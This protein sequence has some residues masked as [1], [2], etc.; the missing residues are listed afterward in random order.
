M[1]IFTL[2]IFDR[3]GNCLFHKDWCRQKVNTLTK[4]EERKL[5]FGMIH[6]IKAFVDKMSPKDGQNG[7]HSYSTNEYKL[8]FYESPTGFKFI[9]TTDTR[10]G[11]ITETLKKIYSQVYVKYVVRNPLCDLNMPISSSLFETKLESFINDLPFY[12]DVSSTNKEEYR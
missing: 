9:L 4:D 11:N 5:L 6:S 1:T 2:Y 12:E 8:H 3:N 7:F 10:V